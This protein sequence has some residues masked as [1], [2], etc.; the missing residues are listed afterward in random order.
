[1]TR[2]MAN[3]AFRREQQQ[4]LHEP[5]IAPI[6]DLIDSLRSDEEWLPYVAPI[7]G[8]IDAR[9]MTV[10]RDP[11]PKTRQG[12]G[13]GM[14]CTENDDQTAAKQCEL[15]AGAGLVPSDLTPWNAYPWYINRAPSKAQIRRAA[16]ALAS[17]VALMPKLRVVLLAGRDAQAAWDVAAQQ[18]PL[19]RNSGL[20]VL[21]TFH[22]SAQALQTSDP[23][24][25][26]RRID[27]RVMTWNEAGR[28]VRMG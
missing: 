6:T 13:S 12:T 23:L 22:A 18:E 19:L 28:I 5:R 25:R 3:P 1:M 26:A 9:M 17:M 20:V 14:L 8:G 15:M 4:R 10:L 11:G 2:Q 24:E 27:H 16:P 21:R 7:H